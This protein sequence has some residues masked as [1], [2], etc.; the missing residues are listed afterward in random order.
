MGVVFDLAVSPDG[1]RLLYRYGDPFEARG[2]IGVV[3][4]GTGPPK[5]AAAVTSASWLGQP[6]GSHAAW[7]DNETLIVTEVTPVDASTIACEVTLNMRRGEGLSR[8]ARRLLAQC[9]GRRAMN[10]T[11]C[12]FGRRTSVSRRSGAMASHSPERSH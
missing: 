4:V 5:F 9:L 2:G 10:V 8:A 6:G 7:L 11:A 3:F 12:V 1:T